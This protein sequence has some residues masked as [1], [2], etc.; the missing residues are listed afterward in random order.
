MRTRVLN[1][2]KLDVAALAADAGS[3]DGVWPAASLERLADLAAADKPLASWPDLR[4]SCQAEIRKPRAAEP[5]VWMRVQ[6][7]GAAFL[8]CQRCLKAVKVPLNL[9]AWFR[10]A[11]DE[12]TAA[13]I[14]AESEEDVLVLARH[15]DLRELIEDELL[16]A[17]PIVP[18]HDECPEPLPMSHGDEEVVEDDAE[19]RP[20]PFA[21]LAAL[22]GTGC[23][24]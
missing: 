23:K 10:F 16:L 4:W 1:P 12:A 17:L 5:Q 18:R 20:T 13:D 19:N 7:Q 24:Q 14:D 22:K 6:A 8:T 3:L 21:A 15:M 9:S 2:L 11:R